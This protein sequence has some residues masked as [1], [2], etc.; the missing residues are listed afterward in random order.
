MFVRP[1]VRTSVRP[2]FHKKFFWF[3]WNLVYR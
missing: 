2:S 1:S 3:Q